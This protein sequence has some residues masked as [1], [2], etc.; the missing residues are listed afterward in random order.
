MKEILAGIRQA[1]SD[2]QFIIVSIFKLAVLILWIVVFAAI[3][4][5]CFINNK[6]R[7]KC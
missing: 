1:F 6:L 5:V 7:G 4:L 2:F 3:F